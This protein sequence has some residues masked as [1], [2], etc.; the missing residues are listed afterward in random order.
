M[1]EKSGDMSFSEEMSRELEIRQEGLGDGKDKNMLLNIGKDW[2]CN[3]KGTTLDAVS[4]EISE[5]GN[6]MDVDGKTVLQG[7]GKELKEKG[8]MKVKKFRRRAQTKRFPP[9]EIKDSELNSHQQGKRKMDCR[10]EDGIEAGEST[11]QKKRNVMKEE[12]VCI[13]SVQVEGIT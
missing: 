3:K 8:D 12:R 11:D 13:M 5:H 10:K 1:G 2:K 4:F 6:C 7:L 9:G